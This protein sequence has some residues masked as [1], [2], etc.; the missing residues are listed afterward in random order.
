MP[1]GDVSRLGD[2]IAHFWTGIWKPASASDL[3]EPG[4]GRDAAIAPL[5]SE[6][7]WREADATSITDLIFDACA[8][9]ADG[10]IFDANRQFEELFGYGPGEASG[11]YLTEL[12]APEARTPVVVARLGVDGPGCAT[13]G[14]RKDGARVPI[15][16]RSRLMPTGGAGVGISIVRDLSPGRDAEQ[17]ER[18]LMRRLVT[19]QE[20]ERRRLARDLHDQVGQTVTAISLGLKALENSVDDAALLGR[21]AWLRELADQINAEIHTTVSTLRPAALDQLGLIEAVTAFAAD[22]SRRYGI[23]VDLQADD[24]CGRLLPEVETATY[25]IVQE[26]LT[27]VAK[28]AGARSVAMVVDISDTALRVVVEDDGVGFDSAAPD[29][30]R[31][32]L[33]GMNERAALVG[34][35]VEIEST[36]GS[37]TSVFIH[38]PLTGWEQSA[39]TANGRAGRAT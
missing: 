4:P 16:M 39:E 35:T 14:L 37:G 13:I 18:M 34:G 21:I 31:H 29:H 7:V 27:N 33:R 9:H 15:E 19:A 17:R 26:A 28:H 10:L 36:R 25:R 30:R 32:G 12:L 20:E 2:D 24:A 5:P 23:A 6:G 38:M 22:W 8:C 1:S 3:V 11:R